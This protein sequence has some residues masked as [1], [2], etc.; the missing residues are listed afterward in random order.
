MLFIS[1]ATLCNIFQQNSTNLIV[2][3]NGFQFGYIFVTVMLHSTKRKTSW[4]YN[5]LVYFTLFI[6]GQLTTQLLFSH[7]HLE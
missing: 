3:S 5:Q 6:Y 2:T 4:Q 7:P 1:S